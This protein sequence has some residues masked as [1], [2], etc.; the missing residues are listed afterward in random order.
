MSS[1]FE[2]P[3]RPHVSTERSRRDLVVAWIAT[4][5]VPAAIALGVLADNAFVSWRGYEVDE[6]EPP[7]VGLAGFALLAVVVAVPVTVALWFGF[8]ASHAGYP[9]G[10]TAA[11]LS[12]IVGGGLVLAGLPVYLARLLGWPVVVAWGGVLAVAAAMVWKRTHRWPPT[13]GHHPHVK[14][15]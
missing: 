14:M 10:T 9:S 15:G 11:L 2:H 13:F 1:T 8:R 5:A 6:Q 12:M 3:L 7:G 4:A